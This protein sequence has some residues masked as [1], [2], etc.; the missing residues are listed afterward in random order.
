MRGE[1]S[2]N[3]HHQHP[4]PMPSPGRA[5]EA[6]LVRLD[7]APRGTA[8]AAVRLVRFY[9]WQPDGCPRAVIFWLLLA[10]YPGWHACVYLPSATVAESRSI[11]FRRHRLTAEPPAEARRNAGSSAAEPKGQAAGQ[12]LSGRGLHGRTLGLGIPAQ[13]GRTATPGLGSLHPPRNQPSSLSLRPSHADLPR[14]R[15][16]SSSAARRS[17]APCPSSEERR[18]GG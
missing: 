18:G 12:R 17:R 15:N 1:L 3:I 2:S 16:H 11:P 7:S 4:T 6:V 10:S 13:A 9:K 5:R 14:H 8:R